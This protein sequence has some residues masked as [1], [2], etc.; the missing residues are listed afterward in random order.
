MPT[1]RTNDFDCHYELDE[2]ADP[3]TTPETVLI[4]HGFGRNG[5]FWYAWVPPLAQRYRVLRRDMRGHGGSGDPGPDYPWSVDVLVND[6]RDFLDALQI[7]RVH[8]IGES[9]GGITGIA[10]AATYPERLA[11]LTLVAAPLAIRPEVQA[12]FARGY[13]DW[14]TALETLGSGGWGAGPEPEEPLTPE[15]EA[16]RQWTRQEWDRTPVH[17]LQS[18]ARFVPSVDAEPLLPQIQAPT[19]ILAPSESPITPLAEQFLMRERIP[20]ARIHVLDGF[21]HGFYQE[22]PGRCTREALAF[23]DELGTRS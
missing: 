14:P 1:V 3:W 8:Y 13:A 16:M 4:Q 15:R 10:F 22:V 9:L 7:E 17:V 5:R 20:D 23:L 12:Q 18:L 2:H 11:S 19:L 6:L 21:G